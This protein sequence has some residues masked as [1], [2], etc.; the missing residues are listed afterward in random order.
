MDRGPARR[1]VGQQV[2]HPVTLKDGACCAGPCN[3]SD[4]AFRR[5]ISRQL[6]K[7]ESLHALRRDL[8]YAQQGTITRPH[9]EQQTEQA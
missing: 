6:N 4:P 3:L 5:K 8:H 1:E 9:L 7:G 2:E